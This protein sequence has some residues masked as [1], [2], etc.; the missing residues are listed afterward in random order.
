MCEGRLRHRQRGFE[1][2]LYV[3]AVELKFRFCARQRWAG[4]T[5]PKKGDAPASANTGGAGIFHA[6]GN[7]FTWPKVGMGSRTA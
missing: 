7:G 2:W 5:L 3:Q 1:L 6:F 4:I